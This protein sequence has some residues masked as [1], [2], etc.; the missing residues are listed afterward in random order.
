MPISAETDLASDPI[1]IEIAA[2]AEARHPARRHRRR[3]PALGA[4][5]HCQ[6]GFQ[7]VRGYVFGPDIDATS[8]AVRRRSGAKHAGV[9]NPRRC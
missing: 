8:R 6:D 5:D 2:L 7:I 9:G 4:I 1:A 3:L